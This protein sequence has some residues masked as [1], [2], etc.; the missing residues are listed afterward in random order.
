MKFFGKIGFWDPSVETKPGV[1]KP[2]IVEKDYYGDVLRDYR[3]FQSRSDDQN[4]DYLVTNQISI[5]GDLYANNHVS[6]IR[7]VTWQGAKWKVNKVEINYPR[8]VLE[9]GGVYNENQT[10]TP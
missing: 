8:L 1:Y 10:R 5:L 3:K 2:Q 9:L 6:S 4:D 7:Y